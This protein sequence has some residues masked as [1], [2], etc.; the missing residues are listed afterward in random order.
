MTNLSMLGNFRR[1]HNGVSAS[2]IGLPAWPPGF[3]GRVSLAD[4]DNHGQETY[5][6]KKTAPCRST[7]PFDIGRLNDMSAY[8]LAI[9]SIRST[10]R[11]L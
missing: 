5:K 6:N 10:L 8:I 9:F 7:A 4:V 1:F 11:Q 2:T 3:Y